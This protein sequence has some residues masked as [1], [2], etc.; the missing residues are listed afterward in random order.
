MLKIWKLLKNIKIWK[1]FKNIK[2]CFKFALNIQNVKYLSCIR[3]IKN[4]I[5]F[6]VKFLLE[7]N[8]FSKKKNYLHFRRN[9][10]NNKIIKS[11]DWLIKYL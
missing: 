7:N 5:N 11:A 9:I 6:V 2:I 8:L 1:L 10:L 4:K 3:K